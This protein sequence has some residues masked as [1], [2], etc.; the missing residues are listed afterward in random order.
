MMDCDTRR[1][2]RDFMVRSQIAARG[3]R[4]RRVLEAM[5]KVPRHLFVP[6]SYGTEAYDDYPLPIGS[7]QTISQPYIVAFMT[8]ALMLTGEERV[9]E[10]GTGSGYQAAVLSL[11]AKKIYSVE[12]IVTLQEQARSVLDSLQLNNVCLHLG[13]G[14]FGWEE[15]APFDAIILS[16]APYDI[17]NTILRQLADRGRL[18]APVGHLGAQILVRITR[19]GA[20]F[21][22]ETLFDVAFVPMRHGVSNI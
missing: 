6:Q 12:R 10:I 15:E 5:R 20:H 18:V 14:F 21:D 11:L 9:L 7:G 1:D 8:E 13:D 17:P 2:E 3:V 4:D 22:T 19:H 16:A